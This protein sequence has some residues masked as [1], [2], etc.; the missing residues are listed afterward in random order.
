MAEIFAVL[1]HILTGSAIMENCL[2][3][4]LQTWLMLHSTQL[5]KILGRILYTGTKKAMDSAISWKSNVYR[6]SPDC[7]ERSDYGSFLDILKQ[8][9]VVVEVFLKLK[10]IK[11]F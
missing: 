1:A 6:K 3:L 9:V 10:Q 5:V 8:Y 7:F 2:I 11:Q 4:T